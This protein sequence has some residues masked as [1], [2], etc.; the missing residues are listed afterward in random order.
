MIGGRVAQLLEEDVIDMVIYG[1]STTKYSNVWHT[2]SIYKDRTRIINL[3]PKG[4]G[5]TIVKGDFLNYIEIELV[6]MSISF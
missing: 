2:K 1:Y 6:Y 4:K 3:S 5:S